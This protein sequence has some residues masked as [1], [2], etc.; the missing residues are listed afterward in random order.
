MKDWKSLSP[1]RWDCKYHLA[2]VSKYRHR[3]IYGGIRKKIGAIVR[4]LFR[5]KVLELHEGHAMPQWIMTRAGTPVLHVASGKTRPRKPVRTKYGV[6][7]IEPDG[8]VG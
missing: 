3:S 4:G 8:R 7:G 2:F 1:V 6:A 5:Q